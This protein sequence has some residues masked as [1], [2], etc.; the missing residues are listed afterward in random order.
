MLVH[1]LKEGEY[2]EIDTDREMY[3]V[4]ECVGL[5]WP[6]GGITPK[7]GYKNL[8]EKGYQKATI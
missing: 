2:R 7:K 4:T 8:F 6:K 1:V 3:I 5:V